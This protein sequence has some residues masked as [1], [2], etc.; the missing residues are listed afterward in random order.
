[1]GPRQ[2]DTSCWKLDLISGFF[3]FSWLIVWAD[4]MESI[5][6]ADVLQEARDADSRALDR[7]QM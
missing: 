2:Y 7:S 4:G 3:A 6:V 5:N 1:M